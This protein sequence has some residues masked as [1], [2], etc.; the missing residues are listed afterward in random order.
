MARFDKETIPSREAARKG[1]KPDPGS[2]R[3]PIEAS[4]EETRMIPAMIDKKRLLI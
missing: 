4:T 1:I 2:P 3:L